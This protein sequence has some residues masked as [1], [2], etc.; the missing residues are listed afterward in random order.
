ML[1]PP[2]SS[3]IHTSYIRLTHHTHHISISALS[4]KR[5]NNQRQ[6]P[7]RQ[8]CRCSANLYA[9][10]LDVRQDNL[11]DNNIFDYDLRLLLV[12]HI[13]YIPYIYIYCMNINNFFALFPSHS[14]MLLA[15]ACVC[16]C[17]RSRSIAK[18]ICVHC[19]CSW[20]HAVYISVCVCIT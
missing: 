8:R 18:Y 17:A 16:L 11:P 15:V 5:K 3:I 7:S 6:P 12:Y 9:R 2:C 4:N 13:H 14:L 10:K 19:Y 1:V 20:D